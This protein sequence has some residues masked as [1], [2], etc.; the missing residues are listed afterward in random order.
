MSRRRLEIGALA[1]IFVLLGAGTLVLRHPRARKL[2]QGAL[3]SAAASTVDCGDGFKACAGQCVSA[4]DP[5]HGCATDS[6]EACVTENASARCD[7]IRMC[8]VEVCHKGFADCDANRN[9]GC[10]TN[11]L[12]DPDHCGGCD[13]A[14]PSLAHAERGCGGGCTIWRC[15][16]GY[17]DC[18]AT[19]DNGCERDIMNDPL[20]CGRCQHA[21][22]AGQRCA[23][24]RCA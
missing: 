6:C 7:A 9:N 2:L 15:D 20:H 4:D 10:E 3:S 8:A 21:C 5:G 24:G 1:A 16:S 23:H 11:V 18:D 13:T 12:I 14:C 19:A 22:R 17:R